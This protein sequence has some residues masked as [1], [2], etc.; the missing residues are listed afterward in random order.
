MQ[1][2]VANGRLVYYRQAASPEYW[3]AAWANQETQ[4]LYESATQGELGYYENV[5]TTYLPRQ[6]RIL[7][8]GCGLGQCVMALRA[9]AYDAE[10][11]DYAKNTID[12]VKMR[13]PDLPIRWGD[14]TKLD[15]SDGYY[16]GYISLGVMEHLQNGPEPFLVEAHR[17]LSD[18]GVALISIPHMN[19]LRRIKVRLGLFEGKVPNDL[20]FYQYVYPTGEFETLLRKSGFESIAHHQYGGYKG[21]KDEIDFISR[22]FE[23][24]HGWRLRKWLMNSNWANNH[25][26]HMMM[27]VCKKQ[28]T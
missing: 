13:F 16:Q 25:M 2:I 4:A 14:V 27:F 7:E 1:R 11:V 8:A 23:W 19:W 24:P 12:N 3:D 20:S 18:D 10:G 28:G 21:V 26:G 9:R 17:V 5:F 15:V 6:G 22:I